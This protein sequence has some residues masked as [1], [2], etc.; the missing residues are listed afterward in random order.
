MISFYN[1]ALLQAGIQGEIKD[2]MMGHLRQ[3][4][5]AHYGYD[6]ATITENY[7]KAFPY[8]SING[9]QSR[10]DIEKLEQEF[11]IKT[12]KL[13]Q[14]STVLRSIL[15]SLMDRNK[16]EQIIERSLAQQNK[17]Q[18]NLSKLSDKE[19]FDIYAKTMQEY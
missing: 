13:E 11:Q 4:A 7:E 17:P 19:L 2:I 14:E 18:I 3:G 16:L 9:L 6:S 5:R 15:L 1:S 12:S 8:L 10:N